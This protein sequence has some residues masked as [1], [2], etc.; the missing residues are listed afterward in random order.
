MSC[1]ENRFRYFE[2]VAASGGA[3]AGALGGEAEAKAVLEQIFN[4][5]R[6]DGANVKSPLQ[7][8]KAA[9]RTLQLFEEM[10][11]RHGLARPT[12]S[13]KGM[14]LPRRDAQFGYQAVYDTIEA[15]RTGKVL[16]DVA[17]RVLQQRQMR[18][19]ISSLRVDDH[20]Y[21]RCSNCGQFASRTREH[22]CPLT[23]TSADLARALH[24]RLGVSGGAYT[25]TDPAGRKVDGLQEL[26]DAARA[27]TGKT[28]GA[29]CTVPMIH[30]LTGEESDVTLDG[31]IPALGQGFVP[32]M[33]VG[34]PGLRHVELS[35][36][37]VVAVLDAMG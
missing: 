5:A 1:E 4:T 36:R 19:T 30:C 20:G 37:R 35:D 23:A 6:S 26:I 18:R 13:T 33:W 29:P 14:R 21:Y 34:R 24:R 9:G 3:L 10:E 27:P 11:Q 28:G 12:H 8:N 32:D 15:A 17:V 7:Q 16:P 31:A 25:C 2:R 22:I